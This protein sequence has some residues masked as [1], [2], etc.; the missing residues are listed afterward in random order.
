MPTIFNMKKTGN[1][2]DLSAMFAAKQKDRE[3]ANRP[4]HEYLEDIVSSTVPANEAVP[5]IMEALLEQMNYIEQHVP[6]QKL[7]TWSMRLSLAPPQT[8]LTDDSWVE[9]ADSY[10][11]FLKEANPAKY[12]RIMRRIDPSERQDLPTVTTHF[13]EAQ[14]AESKGFKMWARQIKDA[15][16]GVNVMPSLIPVSETAAMPAIQIFSTYEQHYN[17]KREIEKYLERINPPKPPSPH[18]TLVT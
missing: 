14:L 15:L 7:H 18:L 6:E 12:E 17:L 8:A 9:I 11:T 4:L 3:N 16:P 1:I 5:L 13:A 10:G 2:I